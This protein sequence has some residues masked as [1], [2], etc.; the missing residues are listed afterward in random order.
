MIQANGHSAYRAPLT[1][2]EKARWHSA[3]MQWQD[4]LLEEVINGRAYF[5]TDARPRGTR[6]TDAAAA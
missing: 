1:E 6:A 5:R 2:G 3:L 4:G